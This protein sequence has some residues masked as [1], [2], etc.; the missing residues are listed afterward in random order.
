[1]LQSESPVGDSAKYL[2]SIVY[3]LSEYVLKWFH[4]QLVGTGILSSSKVPLLFSSPGCVRVL[5]CMQDMHD[6]YFCFFAIRI[7]QTHNKKSS[8]LSC[9]FSSS[10]F[11]F[12]GCMGTGKY[13]PRGG[14][15]S[16]CPLHKRAGMFTTRDGKLL[17]ATRDGRGGFSK[18]FPFFVTQNHPANVLGGGAV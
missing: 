11:K 14:P 9:F 18:G 16:F 13:G 6:L 8:S 10:P 5:P 12:P 3:I 2:Y 15:F 7:I 17:V 4:V 1:M